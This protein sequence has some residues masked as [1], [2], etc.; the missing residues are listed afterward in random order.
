MQ[1][2]H[3]DIKL[4]LV[5]VLDTVSRYHPSLLLTHHQDIETTPPTQPPAWTRAVTSLLSTSPITQHDHHAR[6]RHQMTCKKAFVLSTQPDTTAPMAVYTK[7]VN[8]SVSHTEEGINNMDMRITFTFYT[9]GEIDSPCGYLIRATKHD[10]VLFSW[11]SEVITP[12][13]FLQIMENTVVGGDEMDPTD[14]NPMG[15]AS[16]GFPRRKFQ[17]ER[18]ARQNA[19]RARE[20]RL[21]FHPSNGIG[22]V[23]GVIGDDY[24]SGVQD[25]PERYSAS[26]RILPHN[27]STGHELKRNTKDSDSPANSGHHQRIWAAPPT[28]DELRT[29]VGTLDTIDTSKLSMPCLKEYPEPHHAQLIFTEHVYHRT[30]QLLTLDFTETRY[31]DLNLTIMAKYAHIRAEIDRCSTRLAAVLNTVRQRNT[32]LS[33]I[34]GHIKI[35]S[36]GCSI[37]YRNVQ[38]IYSRQDV[39]DPIL[40]NPVIDRTSSNSREADQHRHDHRN[41]CK[42]SRQRSDT[43]SL[44]PISSEDAVVQNGKQ[45]HKQHALLYAFPPPPKPALYNQ[46]PSQSNCIDP[47][48]PMSRSSIATG[49][50]LRSSTSFG[51]ANNHSGYSTGTTELLI[52]R[53]AVWSHE[54][55]IPVQTALQQLHKPLQNTTKKHIRRS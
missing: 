19:S 10:D 20:D 50:C 9:V 22:G 55:K 39:N 14:G 21:G 41:Q 35:P 1:K 17:S 27:K 2:H 16:H 6:H 12:E 24:L 44:Q 48:Y 47:T 38:S 13:R 25:N 8:V 5:Q 43:V 51:Q 36:D 26:L 31:E 3:D 49:T 15:L 33:M 23:V 7:S 37:A 29:A 46:Y 28:T 45:T 34:L 18:I 42:E 4:A 30:T 53:R 40:K 52:P 54:S 32:S 11:V